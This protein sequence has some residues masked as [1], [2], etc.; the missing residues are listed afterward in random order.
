MVDDLRISTD[1]SYLRDVDVLDE[2]DVH[3]SIT[4]SG[5]FPVKVVSP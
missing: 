1:R 4:V 3:C 2:Q 5:L